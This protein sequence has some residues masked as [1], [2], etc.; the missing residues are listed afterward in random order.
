MESFYQF[1]CVFIA[2]ILF[3][4]LTIVLVLI[5]VF[6]WREGLAWD[7]GS[8]EFNWHPVL[9]TIG[10]I[11][12][13][14]LALIVYRLPW[15]WKFSKLYMKY[16]HAGLNIVAFVLVV[17][18]L[19]AVFDFHNAKNIPNLYSL[20]SWIGLTAVILYALQI[21]TGLCVFLLPATPAW[22]RKFYLPI[23]VFAGLFIFGMVIVAA[24]MGITEKL[25]F[26]L[27]SK[28]NTTRSYSQS[29]PEAILANTLGVFILIFGGCIMWIATHPEWKRPPEFTS[30]AVQIKGNKVNEERSSL[31]AMHANAEANIE[32]DAEGAVRNRNLNLEEPGQR[33]TF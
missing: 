30:M 14:G 31:K 13:Y 7:G 17:I 11:V 28:S 19:V 3:G 27:R 32:Q 23:H 5:W 29:P 33:S 26:T 1:V 10:F 25:I 4:S 2:S 21:V 12:I 16:I 6:E 24:E 9:L 8:A 22:I 18:S 15:T 20:H